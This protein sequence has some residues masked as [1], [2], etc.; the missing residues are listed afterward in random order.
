VPTYSQQV[1]RL[2]DGV[3]RRFRHVVI[4]QLNRRRQLAQVGV[5]ESRSLEQVGVLSLDLGQQRRQTLGIPLGQLARSVV[6]YR[7]GCCV[8]PVQGRADNVNL[9]PA[10]L[11]RSLESPV[12]GADHTYLVH[13]NRLLLP[14]ARQGALDRLDV[15]L[16]VRADVRWIKRQRRYRYAVNV[17]SPSSNASWPHSLTR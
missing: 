2:S 7:V 11:L 10:Q 5:V 12:A 13:D 4:F 14:K 3:C 8:H 6:G 17:H 15:P 16:A 1:S 9:G